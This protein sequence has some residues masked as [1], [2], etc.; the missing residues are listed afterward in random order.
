MNAPTAQQP[1]SDRDYSSGITRRICLEAGHLIHSE[2]PVDEVSAELASLAEDIE[3]FTDEERG[4]LR[5]VLQLL[6]TAGNVAI[7]DDLNVDGEFELA[8]S[9]DRMFMTLAIRPPIAN[10]KPVEAKNII[11]SLRERGIQRGVDLTAIRAAVRDAEAGE[12]VSDVV[13]VKGMPPTPGRDGSLRLYARRRSEDELSPVSEAALGPD[14]EMPWMCREGDVI[15]KL[16]APEPGKPGYDAEGTELA[17]PAVAEAAIE[18]GK[19]VRRDDESLIAEVSGVVRYEAGELSVTKT[20]V[21]RAEVT[22]RDGAVDFDGDIHVHGAVRSQARITATGQVIVYGAV[23]AATIV[24]TGGD[25][26]L[27]HGIAGQGRGVIRAA[28]DITARFAEQASLYAGGDVHLQL[29]TLHSRVQAGQ[30]ICAM[31]GK[32][33]LV[34]GAL[35]AGQ[36]VHAKHLGAAGEAKTKVIVGLSAEAMSKIAEL[37]SQRV[38]QN[39]KQQEVRALAEQMLRAVADP[40]KFTPTEKAVYARLRQIELLAGHAVRRLDDDIQA[41]T[42]AEQDNTHGTVQVLSQLQA[43]VTISIGAAT[44]NNTQSRNACTLMVDEETG[45]IKVNGGDRP[46]PRRTT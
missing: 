38:E 6:N 31:Q 5:E 21:L 4:Q 29:G 42:A 9:D 32:G 19:H 46:A 27:L 10:G 44:Y 26:F 15:G 11:E 43:N 35:I 18:L 23:E 20:L 7:P 2:M 25:V 33:Q 28:G 12:T 17:P 24:S 22:A 45:R 39:G 3:T 14:D 37:D 1:G 13:I 34:G 36:A 16:I 41:I 8:L 40:Q 30:R